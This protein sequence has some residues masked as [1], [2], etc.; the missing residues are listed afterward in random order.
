MGQT[1]DISDYLYFTFY[2][3]IT[4]RKNYSLGELSIGR[5]LGVSH[6]VG[7]MMSYWVLPVS[8][9]VIPCVTVKLLNNSERNT[10]EWSQ[11]TRE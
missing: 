2:D 11:R 1:P 9:H 4:Y 5:W 6:K 3:W 7:Q 10:D 8:G